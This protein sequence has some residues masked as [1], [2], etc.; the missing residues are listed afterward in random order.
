METQIKRRCQKCKEYVL[1]N[2]MY[3]E[4]FAAVFDEQCPTCS[5]RNYNYIGAD[6]GKH[7]YD[8]F[9]REFPKQPDAAALA[10]NGGGR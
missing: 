7:A 3:S 4:D 10:P 5:A 9:E 8:R 1:P 6:D 2:R